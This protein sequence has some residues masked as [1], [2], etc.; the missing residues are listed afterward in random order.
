[1]FIGDIQGT[2]GETSAL[3]ILIGAAI[4]LVFKVIDLKIPLTYYWKFRQYL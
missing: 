3:A 1:M 2:I 4:L